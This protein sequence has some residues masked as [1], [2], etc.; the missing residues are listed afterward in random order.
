M[1]ATVNF[2]LGAEFAIPGTDL[3]IRGGFAYLP[4]PYEFDSSPNDQKFIT[5]GLGWIIQNSVKFDIGYAY[6]YWDTDHVVEFAKTTEKIK[7]HTIIATAS[8]RF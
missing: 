6:G 7:T 4:S 2:R 3:Q 5:G 1:K 8:Y